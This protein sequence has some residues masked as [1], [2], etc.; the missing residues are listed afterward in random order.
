MRIFLPVLFLM[1]AACGRE[2]ETPV[3]VSMDVDRWAI[4]HSTNMPA[5]PTQNG[6]GWYFD[7]PG[8]RGHVHYVMNSVRLAA[9][10]RASADIEVT[11]RAPVFNKNPT[12]DPKNKCPALASMRLMI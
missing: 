6:N 9:K 12:K 3:P 1:L 2:T 8:P 10:S 11:G 4:L 7:F 5:R